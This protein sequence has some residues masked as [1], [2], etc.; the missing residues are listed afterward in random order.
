VQIKVAIVEDD[1]AFGSLL[2]TLLILS[3]AAEVVACYLSARE[4]LDQLPQTKA[5]VVLIAATLEGAGG[6]DLVRRLKA[7]IPQL[8]II[9]L[10]NS[11]EEAELL[12]GL[13]AG[14]E[15][16][17]LKSSF[18]NE[19][20]GTLSAVLSGQFSLAPQA[21]TILAKKFQQLAVASRVSKRLTRRERQVIS[22]LA[23]GASNKE[24]AAALFISQATTHLH[25]RNIYEK[26]AVHSRAAAVTAYFEQERSRVPVSNRPA[27]NSSVNLALT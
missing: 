22:L 26:L 19:V 9:V 15:G 7:T 12:D 27:V 23:T 24:I 4:A 25:L 3:S 5:H 16:Y 21:V 6:V 8:K 20:R 14:A 18:P 1:I 13:S 2:K 11:I 17:I 10:T